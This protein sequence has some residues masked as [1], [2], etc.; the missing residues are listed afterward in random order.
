MNLKGCYSHE[1]DKIMIGHGTV[2]EVV[3]FDV[4]KKFDELAKKPMEN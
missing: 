4:S 3:S 2:D 1:S